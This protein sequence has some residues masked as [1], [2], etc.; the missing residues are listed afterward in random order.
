MTLSY[1][2]LVAKIGHQICAIRYFLSFESALD[3]YNNGWPN[4][5]QNHWPHQCVNDSK[6]SHVDESAYT[7]QK[8]AAHNY[9]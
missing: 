3:K 6:L 5:F 4:Q 1:V 9:A 2:R 8:Q 7:T